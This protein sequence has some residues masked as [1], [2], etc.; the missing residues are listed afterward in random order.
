MSVCICV[1]VSVCVS[2]SIS[3]SV[4]LCL[5]VCLC[6]SLYISVCIASITVKRSTPLLLCVVDGEILYYDSSMSSERFIYLP[7]VLWCCHHSLS[8]DRT[9]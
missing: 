7:A 9:R 6:V 5:R 3:V 1:C 4:Y 8:Q 2:V